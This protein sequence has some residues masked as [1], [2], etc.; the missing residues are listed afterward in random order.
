M[1][2]MRE[3]AF[4]CDDS[5]G[6][7]L[8]RTINHSHATA[9]DLL[10]NFVMTKAPLCVGHIRFCEDA[11]ERFARGLTLSFKSLPQETVDAGSVIELDCGA[12]LWALLRILCY[13]RN[14]IRRLSWFV[15]HAAAASAAHKC[16]I[17]S[18][19]SA[20]FATV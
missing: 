13:V 14:R 1:Y 11:F 4:H 15:H 9:S 16:R 18:S 3:D 7:L 2:L 5:T 19:T 10:Q 8:A 20:G 6:V 17:S 12:A